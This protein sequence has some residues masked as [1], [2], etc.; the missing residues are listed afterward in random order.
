MHLNGTAT[1]ITGRKMFEW[2]GV[3]VLFVWGTWS[4]PV[5]IMG[6]D[7]FFVPGGL[8]E[9]RFHVYILEHFHQYVT[10]RTAEF[11]SAP[12]MH[13]LPDALACWENH[14]G[15]APVFS[16]FRY[17]GL[18]RESAFQLWFLVMLSLNFWF[19]IFAFRSWTRRILV[20]GCAAFIFTF[21][22]WTLDLFDHPGTYARF[23]IPGALV[24][25]WKW[26]EKGDRPMLAAA[27]LALVVQFYCSMRTGFFLAQGMLL[28]GLAW[29]LVHRQRAD[30]AAHF[31]LRR[32]MLDM[33]VV[34]GGLLLLLPVLWPYLETYRGGVG[35]GNG[36]SPIAMLMS[37]FRAHPDALSWRDLSPDPSLHS[38]ERSQHSFFGVLPWVAIL[39]TPVLFAIRKPLYNDRAMRVLMAAVGLSFLFHLVNGLLPHWPFQAM[40]AHTSYNDM[41]GLM[42]VQIVLFLMAG[43]ALAANAT[44]G[45]WNAA[46]L[47][48]LLGV[49]VVLDNRVEPRTVERFDKW[50]ARELVRDVGRHIS[51]QYDGA[52][53]IAYIPFL[54]PMDPYME[55]D[56]TRN[57]DV[58][59]MLA[60]QE[61]AIPVV[62]G[63]E[64][65][66]TP[67]I[68]HGE[69]A[70]AHWCAI[71]GCDPA[72]IQLINDL[73]VPVK[74]SEVIRVTTGGLRLTIEVGQNGLVVAGPALPGQEAEFRMVIIM[75][76]R[77]AFR[78]LNGLFLM[79]FPDGDGT[80]Y[81]AAPQPGDLALFIPDGR[82]PGPMRLKAAN[83]SYLKLDPRSGQI[84]AE[85]ETAGE[86][87]I[88]DLE[89]E[90]PDL[91]AG[92]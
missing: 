59:A 24:C 19:C 78:G 66:S 41:A 84:R 76:G 28:L 32:S 3:L 77:V 89:I 57:T 10:G 34:M 8:G 31:N 79:I 45:T 62:N 86:A 12:F 83:G 21:G 14:L 71:G 48:A 22:I 42:N 44:P 38:G 53:A 64:R 46:W 54:Q 26:L 50:Y 11:W 39:L 85:A 55:K 23:M 63:L 1:G 29:Y 35:T 6:T 36:P 82:I 33:A 75:D 37:Y 2:L 18:N 27:V 52:Q 7:R 70:L 58:T 91:P 74:R 87:T 5:A 67:L 61:W 40:P 51:A 69:H 9:A 72:R 25:L 17:A 4:L 73:D 68:K 47:L 92:R 81:A 43:L 13:P 65:T 60:A 56:R 90:P 16:L 30:A 15:T 88:F 80:L 49:A 20:S